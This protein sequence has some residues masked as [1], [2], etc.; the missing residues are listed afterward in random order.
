M[1]KY[2]Y[3]RIYRP[4]YPKRRLGRDNDGGYVICDMSGDY[5]LM[6]SGGI[7]KDISFEYQLLE[8]YPKLICH[9]FDG[10]IDTLPE[11]NYALTDGE[12]QWV[13]IKDREHDW[14]QIG[15]LFRSFGTR[16]VRS[17]GCPGWNNNR[18][19]AP[20]RKY[21]AIMKPDLQLIPNPRTLT[22]LEA[23]AEYPNLASEQDIVNNRR[24]IFHRKYLGQHNVNQT[25][26]LREYFDQYNNI[27]MKLDIEGGEDDLF[28]SLTDQ[29]LT[30]IKQLVIEFHSHTQVKIPTRLLKTHWLVHIHVNNYQSQVTIDGHVMLP[31]IFECTYVRKLEGEVLPFSTDPIPSPLDQPNIAGKSDVMLLGYP[32]TETCR[33]TTWTPDEITHGFATIV[34]LLK[35]LTD[36]NKEILR[37][38]KV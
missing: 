21:L 26:N 28:D 10:S 12:D 33:Y 22:W 2:D 20:S 1:T 4:N 5:D 15:N 32:Y 3:L 38:L 24:I 37:L 9:A 34:S 11:R 13:P 30:K 6:I 23:Q 36:T 7:D 35:E 14:I 27:F 16:H 31:E 19:C 25:T 29:D 8:L 18:E 17:F